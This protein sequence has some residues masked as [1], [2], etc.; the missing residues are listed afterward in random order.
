MVDFLNPEIKSKKILSPKDG[1][2]D[3]S[4]IK[5]G[6]CRWLDENEVYWFLKRNPSGLSPLKNKDEFMKIYKY[7]VGF[8]R[9]EIDDEVFI[10][11][12]YIVNLFSNIVINDLNRP[13]FSKLV[14][15]GELKTYMKNSPYYSHV[16]LNYILPKTTW[17]LS[18]WREFDKYVDESYEV[19]QKFDENLDLQLKY[20]WNFYV[21]YGLDF[22]ILVYSDQLFEDEKG[23]KICEPGHDPF[24]QLLVSLSYP[25]FSGW[26][27]TTDIVQSF[28]L[29]IST[30]EWFNVQPDIQSFKKS[31]EMYKFEES[32]SSRD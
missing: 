17:G 10:A 28:L 7:I 5:E 2:I 21:S 22:E 6:S 27:F 24:V 3:Y 31:D 1:T 18:D 14:T 12:D 11:S 8:I 4:W 13:D 29:N 23:N 16:P 20:H 32:W 9:S 19:T 26:N 25:N 15:D 30:G